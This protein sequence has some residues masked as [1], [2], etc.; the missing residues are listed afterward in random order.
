MTSNNVTEAETV[1]TSE[2]QSAKAVDDRLIGELVGRVQTEG[3]V[4]DG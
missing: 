1:E 2:P 4:A 3:P